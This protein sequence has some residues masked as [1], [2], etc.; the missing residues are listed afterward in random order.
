[1]K[2]FKQFYT[3]VMQ[4]Y[5]SSWRG[6]SAQYD[7]EYYDKEADKL[8]GND[9]K[10]IAWKHKLKE[11]P[12][13]VS[14]VTTILKPSD[15]VIHRGMSHDEYQNILKTG[16]IRS[17]GTGNLGA[18]QEGLT[19]LTKDPA[20]AQSYSNTFAMKKNV[21]TENKPAYIV[22]IK[23]PHPDRIKQI[24]G[25]GEHEVGITGDISAD[26]IVS[27]HRGKVIQHD[28]GEQDISMP[29]GRGEYEKK[30]YLSGKLKGSRISPTSRLHW[31]KIK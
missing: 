4:D 2:T 9:D 29:Y 19:Y 16:K 12:S 23:R 8:V 5:R 18:E 31:E 14:D 1:M 10:A 22:S 11:K 15:D 20:A 27:V 6:K 30:E 7:P 21:P 17:K 13:T 24:E 25:T 3:E 26:D 28:P